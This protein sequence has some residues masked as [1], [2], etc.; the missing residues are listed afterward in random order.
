MFEHDDP[1][2]ADPAGDWFTF[3][4]GATFVRAPA[5]VLA[6]VAPA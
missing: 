4:K 3:E 5:A 6:V 1:V 2:S